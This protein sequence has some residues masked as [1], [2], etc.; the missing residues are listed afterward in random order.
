[1]F[2]QIPA[3]IVLLAALLLPLRVFAADCAVGEKIANV[4]I[5]GWGN[6]DASDLVKT[7]GVS[8]GAPF[9]PE[10]LASGTR[11]LLDREVFEDVSASAVER[12][13]E[14]VVLFS[15][16]PKLRLSEVRLEG[17]SVLSWSY[18]KRRIGTTSGGWFDEKLLERLEQRTRQLYRDEGFFGVDVKTSARIDRLSGGV[19]VTIVVREGPRSDL[20]RVVWEDSL[21]DE[22]KAILDR[23]AKRREVVP[24]SKQNIKNAVQDILV[25]LRKDGYLQA[26]VRLHAISV[27]NEG[28]VAFLEVVPRFP[29]SLVFEGNTVFT[30]EELLS[31]LRIETR[32]VYFS[33]KAI[34]HLCQE[35]ERLYQQ[36]GYFLATATPEREE[37]SDVRKIFRIVIHEGG[38][39]RLKSLTV[40]GSTQFSQDELLALMETKPA[41]WMVRRWW[42]PGFVVKE[43]LAADLE[44]LRAWYE[45]HGFFRAEIGFSL[46]IDEEQRELALHLQVKENAQ[47]KVTGCEISWVRDGNAPEPGVQ[48]ALTEGTAMTREAVE[49]ERERILRL[50]LD[51]GYPSAFVE[52]VLDHDAGSVRYEVS[53]GR[54][55]RIRRILPRGNLFTK[56]RVILRELKVSPGDPWVTE[57]IRKSEQNLRATGIFQKVSAGPAGDGLKSSEEDLAIDVVERDSAM[58]DL[59]AVYNSQDGLHLTGA[60]RQLNFQG[61]GRSLELN[62][63]GYFT[64]SSKVFEAGRVRMLYYEPYV[65]GTE[66]KLFLEATVRT[67]V[68]PTDVYASDSYG[69]S[70]TVR[71]GLTDRINGSLGLAV[72]DERTFDV[73]SDVIIGSHDVGS[74]FYSLVSGEIRGDWRDDSFN[75]RRGIYSSVRVDLSSPVTGSNVDLAE[76]VAQLNGYIPISNS[77]VW[78]NGLRV[79]SVA[80]FGNTATVPIGRRLFLGGLGSLRGFGRNAVGP[81][82]SEGHVAGGDLSFVFSSELQ[83][84]V[85]DPVSVA[86]FVDAGQAFLLHPGAFDGSLPNLRNTSFS[87]GVGLRVKT[88]IGPI[89]LDYGLALNPFGRGGGAGRVSLSIGSAF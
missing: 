15:V 84:D 56:D 43:Q 46:D 35:I 68:Y 40:D 73:E 30:V 69:L 42:A 39:L 80:P 82:G 50:V 57:R 38:I 67:S 36:K 45:D 65:A 63:D 64:A 55:V 74:T 32:T 18:L 17:N 12:A 75:P 8:V 61:E 27:E 20:V 11:G 3:L 79:S 81:V 7:T 22:V 53:S 72:L 54:Q 14:C 48:C 37:S 6:L 47:T 9:G 62:V 77:T 4:E 60:L 29:L 10:T 19:I 49:T 13:G 41:G 51:A 28:V 59:N 34:D 71:R 21:P 85:I 16:K 58:L 1:M 78:S 87:P 66:N 31:P 76:S 26:S 24:A 2:R 86:E 25:A 83:E 33:P 44:T 23:A 70:A 88:P 52:A 89:R 5:H